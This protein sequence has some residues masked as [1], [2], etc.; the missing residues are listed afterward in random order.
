MVFQKIAYC[1]FT[2]KVK[3]KEKRLFGNFK[4]LLSVCL[5]LYL[6]QLLQPKLCLATVFC[7]LDTQQEQVILAESTLTVLFAE[8]QKKCHWL[9]HSGVWQR[10]FAL[11]W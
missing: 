9:E 10:G 7:F 4:G 1:S 3:S 8:L 5:F 2:E 6:S 11:Y